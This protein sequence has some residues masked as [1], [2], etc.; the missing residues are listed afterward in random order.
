MFESHTSRPFLG[1]NSLAR[2]PHNYI[3]GISEAEKLYTLYT[4]IQ[5]QNCR[6]TTI[7]HVNTLAFVYTTSFGLE[8]DDA[9]SLD[10]A[11]KERLTAWYGRS[12]YE[13]YMV[14]DI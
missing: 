3:P 2:R 7:K 13:R 10:D 12:L 9:K 8:K 14:V 6:Q 5:S 4:L 1:S 11:R